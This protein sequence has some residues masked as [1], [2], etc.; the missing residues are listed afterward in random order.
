MRRIGVVNHCRTA[1][2]LP[3]LVFER[4]IVLDFLT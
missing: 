2:I 3:A 4:R 1:G